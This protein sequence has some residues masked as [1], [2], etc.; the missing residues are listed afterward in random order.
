VNV[1][2]CRPYLPPETRQEL[3]RVLASGYLTEGE[4]TRKLEALVAE[5]SGCEHAAAVTSCTVGLEIGLRCLGIGPGDE[6][7]V[8]DYTFPSTALSV[9]NTGAIPVLVDVDPATMLMDMDKAGAAVSPKTKAVVPVSIFGNP[10][11][12]GRLDDFRC[13]HGLLVMEDAACALGASQKGRLAGSAA[14]LSVFSFHP[15]KLVTTG[16]GG[17]IVTNDA[18]L[19]AKVRSYAHFGMDMNPAQREGV[20]FVGSG[21]NSKLS[22]IQAVLGVVQLRHL[23]EILTRRR[24]QVS[25][26]LEL[27]RDIPGIVL[28]SVTS[29]GEHSWQSFCLFVKNRDK[30]LGEL[31]QRGVEAQIGTYA[32]HLHDFFVR[33]CRIP[34]PLV[35][36]KEAFGACL[37]LP[38]FHEMLDKEQE[39][40]VAQLREA[41]RG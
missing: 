23:D 32:L 16:E 8:P 27:L 22:N 12:Y 35:G 33:N 17:M 39:Y 19:A 38:L 6:V 25:R 13:R 2:L 3:D 9:M 28:P 18:K 20:H 15:R 34:G 41:V 4:S 11:D 40:V 14:E 29:D 10:V 31:R 36:S 30:V 21:T 5:A 7:L 24:A 1:P 37:A 26:Y